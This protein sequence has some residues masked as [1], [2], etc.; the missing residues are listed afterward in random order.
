MDKIIW[1]LGLKHSNA[2]KSISWLSP[3]PNFSNCDVLV[4]NLPLLEEEILKKRQADLNLEA[5]RY[6]F[7]MLMARKDVIVILSANQNILSWLPI[8]P[9]INKVAPVKMKEDKGKTPW[10]AYLKT[11]EECDY[12]IRKFAFQ[13]IKALT[14]PG[15]EY[16]EN[17]YFTEIAENSHYFLDIATE[18]EVKNRAEQVIGACIRF[19]IRYGDG[20]FYERGTF[21]SGSIT[22]L[23]PPTRVSVEEAI[24]L[25]INTL[26]GAEIA[27]PSP[28]WED[29]I[30]LPGLKDINEKIQQKERDKEKIIKEIRELQTEKDNLVKFRWLLWTKGTPLEN[31]VRDA[32]IFLGF[33]EI[34]KI[35]EENLEDW[36]IEFKHIKQYQ[37]GVFEIKGADERTSLADLTQCNKWVEDYMLENKKA[38]GIFVTNQYRSVD[39]LKNQEKRE[40]FEKNEIEYAETRG[41]CILPTHE[42]FYATVE[43]LNKNPKITRKFIEEKIANS[44]GICRLSET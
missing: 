39:P 3:F 44:K 18:L 32:F 17:Y 14:D 16:H 27:E 30:D 36:V 42:I 2:R 7:D 4:I 13:Y 43:K 33:P 34:R 9:V 10:D 15:S 40:H 23:P 31:A 28:P 22:F 8:Y 25:V 19:I 24:D 12:Y 20:V 5:R 38:K 37:Y 29:Q 26:T 21:V 41:I 6:I 1:V 11:V 35:R